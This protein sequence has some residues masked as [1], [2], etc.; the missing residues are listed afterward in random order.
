MAR[1]RQLARAFSKANYVANRTDTFNSC[2]K[3]GKVSTPDMY[4]LITC[5]SFVNCVPLLGFV[6][7]AGGVTP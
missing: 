7:G 5:Q 3:E 1:S 2:M 4:E 6:V